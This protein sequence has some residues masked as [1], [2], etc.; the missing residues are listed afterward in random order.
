[1][2][3]DMYA[4][5]LASP[6]YA[7]LPGKPYLCNVF[8]EFKGDDRTITFGFYDATKKLIFTFSTG[9]S[10]AL[11]GSSA[12]IQ[13]ELAVLVLTDTLVTVEDIHA[14]ALSYIAKEFAAELVLKEFVVLQAVAG[15]LAWQ[16]VGLTKSLK[17]ISLRYD[18]Q[19]GDLSAVSVAPFAQM[20]AGNGGAS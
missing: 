4:A 8:V 6:A 20:V 3:L 18:A 5:V 7:S 11:V 19:S 2:L 16:Y 10:V 17:S 1:M 15:V 12:P 9:P 13:E 14:R